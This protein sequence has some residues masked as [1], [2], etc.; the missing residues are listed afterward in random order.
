VRVK[1]TDSTYTY[2]YSRCNP[3]DKKS[4]N[5]CI[6][7]FLRSSDGTTFNHFL[8]FYK[9]IHVF[10][11]RRSVN[12]LLRYTLKKTVSSDASLRSISC[13]TTL[14]NFD[15]S[16]WAALVNSLKGKSAPQRTVE[17]EWMGN[18]D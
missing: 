13:L 9:S 3:D 5:A 1:D 12:K 7:A 18:R 4:V 6:K 16:G 10:K 14:Y 8:D 2:M 17:R 15:R 11:G